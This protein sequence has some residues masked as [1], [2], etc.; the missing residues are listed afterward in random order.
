[1]F[2][3]HFSSYNETSMEKESFH[4]TTII[5]RSMFLKTF[6]GFTW[7]LRFDRGV[8]C[9]TR[10]I[11]RSQ[12]AG[13]KYFSLYKA[14]W[15]SREYHRH[16]STSGVKHR[17]V[18]VELWNSG[19]HFDVKKDTAISVHRGAC[20]K[21]FVFDRLWL[22]ISRFGGHWEG[23]WPLVSGQAYRGQQSWHEF[24][25]SG[26]EPFVYWFLMFSGHIVKLR[27]FQPKFSFSSNRQTVIWSCDSTDVE[28]NILHRDYLKWTIT[29]F[30]NSQKKKFWRLHW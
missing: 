13:H 14:L 12:T 27:R 26:G 15:G 1:M 28:G 3:S 8:I 17:T 19:S 10:F 25:H 23:Q 11:Y 29:Y 21:R 24:T 9:S 16:S 7:Y 6:P 5:Q 2:K 4:R 22:M 30:C 20:D 18:C